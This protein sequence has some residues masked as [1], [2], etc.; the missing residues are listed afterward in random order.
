MLNMVKGASAKLSPVVVVITSLVI[1]MTLGC[2]VATCFFPRFPAVIRFLYA[3]ILSA[4]LVGCYLRSPVAYEITPDDKL[5][6]QFRLGS[7][8]FGGVKKVAPVAKP[9]SFTIRL[10]GNGGL[11]ALTGI[12]WNR[13]Y[14][15]FR[16]YVTN[17][18]KLVLVELMDGKKIVISP[19]NIEEWTQQQ[20]TP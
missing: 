8:A 11:F 4:L 18:K 5:I 19:E 14:G 15:R 20:L 7:R 1:L 16:A 13:T 9:V 2:L 3:V 17:L 6:V 12:Y 10:W